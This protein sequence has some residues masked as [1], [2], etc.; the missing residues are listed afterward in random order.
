MAT[1]AENAW[2]FQMIEKGDVTFGFNKSELDNDAKIALDVIAQKAQTTP[3]SVV[4][5]E[6][7]TDK[8]GSKEYNLVLSRRR[9]EAVA[10]YLVGK[11]IPLRNVHIIGL[12]EEAPPAELTADL[13]AVDPN[14]TRKD[15]ARLARRVYIR[16]YAPATA[17]A[18]EAARSEP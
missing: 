5:L 17:I 9:A 10:R 13:A 11:S 2:N 16:V 3:R 4:E 6:G 8:V 15:A 14:P 12:G 1:L 7:F 18:G